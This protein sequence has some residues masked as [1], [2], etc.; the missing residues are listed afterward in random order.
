MTIE[1]TVQAV[2]DR[3]TDRFYGKY[4][5]L[6]LD[7]NDP[8][9]RGRIMATVPE[10]L[11]VV[12]S[13]WAEPCVPYAGTTSGFYA[14]PPIGGGVWIEFEAGDPSRPV[15]TGCWWATGE[16]PLNET[17][18]PPTPFRKILRTETGLQVSL[19]DLT[20]TIKIT[21]VAGLNMVS[22][23][24]LE[25]TVEIQA[26]GRVVLNAPLI[27]HGAA[28]AHPAVLGDELLAYLTTITTIFNTHVHPGEL[29][30]G[31]IPVTPAPAVAPM[32]PPL[33][34]LLSVTNLVQ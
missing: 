26:I 11:G 22:V 7:N 14:L 21:D 25:G 12:P 19:D 1:S 30:A 29:A 6:V 13:G 9:M 18:A 17:L 5:G 27:E 15:W 10:V 16:T 28:A 23:K 4:R 31:V 34:T 8:M 20:Q 32:P 3:Q 2:A 33:P 24:V